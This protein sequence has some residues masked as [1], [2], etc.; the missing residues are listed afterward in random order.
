VTLRSVVPRPP[1]T[2][3]EL[4]EPVEEQRQ[5]AVEYVAELKRPPVDVQAALTVLGRLPERPEVARADLNEAN[6]TKANLY[7]AN[8]TE[9]YL[10]EANL[11]E[12]N[13]QEAN[14]TGAD[15][16]GANLTGALLDGA[17]LTGANLWNANLTGARLFDADLTSARL[18]GAI[19]TEARLHGANLTRVDHLT[20]AQLD[21]ATGGSQ[22]MLPTG[23]QRPKSWT[24]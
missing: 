24:S 7:G 20:Q 13:L 9:A 6:L 23:L 4:A 12:A 19:L 16:Y 3:A 17:D 1:E 8:L 5:K 21:S 22:T 18:M 10:V 15:V 14:L 11:T 2:T